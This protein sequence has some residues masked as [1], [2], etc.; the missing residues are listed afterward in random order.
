MHQWLHLLA[1][2]HFKSLLWPSQSFRYGAPYCA[3]NK[4]KQILKSNWLKSHD[5]ACKKHT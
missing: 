1:A 3:C 4:I 5:V 2:S